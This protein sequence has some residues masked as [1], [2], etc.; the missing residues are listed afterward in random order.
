[1]TTDLALK[2]SL[3]FISTLT[4]Y[5]D[6]VHA[7]IPKEDWEELQREI[8]TLI[9]AV[10]RLMHIDPSYETKVLQINAQ[11]DDLFDLFMETPAESLVREIDQKARGQAGTRQVGTLMS[12][13]IAGDTRQVATGLD[14][15]ADQPFTPETLLTAFALLSKRLNS[16]AEPFSAYPRLDAPAEVEPEATFEVIVG[17]RA[18][19]DP[20]LE[21]GKIIF[22]DEPNPDEPCLVIL[23]V[24][25]A[26]VIGEH[27]GHLPLKQNVAL[28]FT[29]HAH[30][31]AAEILLSVDYYYH[32]QPIGL[33]QR[34]VRLSATALPDADDDPEAEVASTPIR[35][36]DA[37]QYVDLSLTIYKH[38]ASPKLSWSFKSHHLVGDQIDGIETKLSDPRHF[39][40][41]MLT[42]LKT[43]DFKGQLAYNIL[44]NIGRKIADEMPPEFFE[45]LQAVYQVIKR[46]PTLLILTNEPYIPWELALLDEPLDPKH[47]PFLTTQSIIGRWVYHKRVAIP[48]P[49]ILNIAQTTVAASD[50]SDSRG[51]RQ[52]S[53][54]LRERANLCAYF[55]DC[56]LAVT[57]LEMNSAEF[58]AFLIRVTSEPGHLL[59]IA[60]H[61]LVDPEANEQYL[62]LAGTPR[63]KLSPSAMVPARG[64]DESPRFSFV[65]LNACQVGTAGEALGQAAGFPGDLIRNGVQGFIAPLWE[66][67]ETDAQELAEAFYEEAFGDEARPLAEFL[68]NWRLNYDPN[69]S[70]TP[71]A[72]IFYGH[73]KLRLEVNQNLQ[74][75]SQP[76]GEQE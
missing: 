70:T 40:A 33:A 47:P 23:R 1:M 36:P 59:H 24:E 3:L 54:A 50:Y 35:P 46:I 34:R 13:T 31:D 69:G 7:L 51:L 8:D 53:L 45:T 25:G 39:C 52:L 49:V 29:C 11:V 22:I 48:P 17:F 68:H 16:V 21:A 6:R 57:E 58:E 4:D 63:K 64:K 56:R 27:R 5:L 55:R 28:I 37:S 73:P 43:E 20:D 32:N 67:H 44:T 75:H 15:G 38:K 19:A 2:E 9:E 66:I 30:A 10:E 26:K 71:L 14:E 62:L 12:V 74:I 42:E 76:T 72:Y 61:G 65:F 18:E 41:S 60:A